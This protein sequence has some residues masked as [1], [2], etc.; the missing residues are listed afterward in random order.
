MLKFQREIGE[1]L[2]LECGIIME[3]RDIQLKMNKW[4][5]DRS[6]KISGHGRKKRNEIKWDEKIRNFD[7]SRNIFSLIW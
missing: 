6:S 4:E 5:M 3:E 2:R 1:K 7:I